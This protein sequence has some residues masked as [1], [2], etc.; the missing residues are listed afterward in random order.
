MLGLSVAAVATVLIPA[1]VT[2][3]AAVMIFGLA[4]VVVV[5]CFGRARAADEHE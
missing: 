5:E 4:L 2:P 3:L 1:G